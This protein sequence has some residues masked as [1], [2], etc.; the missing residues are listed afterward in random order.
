[1]A[2]DR[3]DKRRLDPVAALHAGVAGIGVA[4]SGA[5]AVLTLLSLLIVA[6]LLVPVTPVFELGLGLVLTLTGIIAAGALFRIAVLGTVGEARRGGLGAGGLQFGLTEMRIVWGG[7]LNL[8]FLSMVLVVLCLVTLAVFGIAG[9]DVAAIQAR[10]WPAV[11]PEWK[12]AALALISLVVILIPVLLIT[13]LS[14]W[15]PASVGRARTVSLNS[16]GIAH[17]AFLPLLLLWLVIGSLA[18][19]VGAMGNLG[20][21]AGY[22]LVAML[23]PWILAPFSAGVLSS[24]YRQLEYWTPDQID[25]GIRTLRRM[26]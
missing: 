9:L 14:L 24:A 19:G 17:G 16:M 15:A 22:V 12:L 23:V 25:P 13:R 4:W 8:I 20:Q 1:M 7:L 26:A 10:N 11:G 21:L 18:A 3:A 2:S 5:W 6:P